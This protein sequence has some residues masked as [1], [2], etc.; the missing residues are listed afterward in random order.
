MRISRTH[1]AIGSLVFLCLIGQA[2][3]AGAQ[4]IYLRGQNVQ[5]VFEGWERNA[6]GTF[7]MIFGYLNR[8]YQEEPYIPVGPNNNFAPGPADRGQPTH[9]YPRR[10]SFLFRVTVPADWGE[11]KLEWTMTHSGKPASAVGKLLPVWEVDEGV[12]NATR[13]GSVA[14]NT[15]GGNAPPAVTVVGSETAT[16]TLG[17]PL[18][19]TFSASDDGTPG[20]SPPAMTAHRDPGPGGVRRRR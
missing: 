7:T 5:P 9:F 6:D 14:G 2:G 3:S 18:I 1:L 4:T 11:Q 10:Q 15:E 8:N 19:L 12:W 17:E 20:R 16:V 13:L